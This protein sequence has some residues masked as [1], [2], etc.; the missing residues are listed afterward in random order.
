MNCPTCGCFMWHIIS[1]FA[2]Y[3]HCIKCTY[4]IDVDDPEEG[5]NNEVP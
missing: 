3:Y 2:E 4:D 5:E 1:N